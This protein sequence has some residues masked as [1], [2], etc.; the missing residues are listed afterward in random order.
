M[1]NVAAAKLQ[2]VSVFKLMSAVSVQPTAV[3]EYTQ[4]LALVRP[5]TLVIVETT[6]GTVKY[7]LR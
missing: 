7:K 1:V 3:F 4:W 5:W 2:H 6:A